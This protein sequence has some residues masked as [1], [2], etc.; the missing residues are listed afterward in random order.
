MITLS[1]ISGIITWMLTLLSFKF[2]A[3]IWVLTTPLRQTWNTKCHIKH[4][5]YTCYMTVYDGVIPPLWQ[6]WNTKVSHQTWNLKVLHVHLYKHETLKCHIKPETWNCHMSFNIIMKQMY[7]H[8][9]YESRGNEKRAHGILK[10]R[11]ATKSKTCETSK[12][13]I[14]PET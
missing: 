3:E 7:E 8:D 14:N 12:C 1:W 13:H 4:E 11:Q 2:D 6:T 10:C 9:E 5:T